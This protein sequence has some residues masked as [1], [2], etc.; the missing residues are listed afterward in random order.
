MSDW[1][2]AP[3]EGLHK[4]EE[5]QASLMSKAECNSVYGNPVGGQ[6]Q[7]SQ[8]ISEEIVWGGGDCKNVLSWWGFKLCTA[9][10]VAVKQLVTAGN[11]G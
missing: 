11:S 8:L 1:L 10:E 2:P 6:N 3:D 5:I 9:G 4:S 7:A